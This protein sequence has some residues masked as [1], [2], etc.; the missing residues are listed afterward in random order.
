VREH[1]IE[2][3]AGLPESLPVGERILWQGA[4]SWWGIACHALH[5]RAIAIYL[6]LIVVWGTTS[7]IAN[8]EQ[9]AHTAIFALKL[10]G[11]SLT[12]L[13]ALAFYARLVTRHTIYTLTNRRV[14]MRFGIALPM[15]MNIPLKTIL[16]ADL[17]L[18]SNG[19]GDIPLAV[20]SDRRQSMVVLW[21]HVR[22]WRTI[23]PEPMLRSIPNA[24]DVAQMLSTALNSNSTERTTIQVRLPHRAIVKTKLRAADEQIV[25][26]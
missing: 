19:S 17:K 13:A 26:A 25:A 2:P 9:A 12:A 3:I 14:V 11:L 22:P 8:H 6:A 23:K 15:T 21:P 7:A 10:M 5:I 20:S 16:S 1:D 4:P 24:T 18:Y